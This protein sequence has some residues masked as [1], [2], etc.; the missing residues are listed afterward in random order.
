MCTARRAISKQCG[1]ELPWL[2]D[3]IGMQWRRA[4]DA[5]DVT[6]AV[7]WRS[8]PLRVSQRVMGEGNDQEIRIGTLGRRP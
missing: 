4:G 7:R 6:S 8:Y 5:C 1:S 3:P 2:L